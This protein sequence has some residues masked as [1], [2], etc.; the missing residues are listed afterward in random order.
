MAVSRFKRIQAKTV[1]GE[2]SQPGHEILSGNKVTGW[3]VNFPIG[4]TCKPSKLCAETC[5]GLKGPITWRAALSKQAR[6]LAYCKTDPVGFADALAT[7]CEKRLERDPGFFLRWNGVGDLFPEAVTAIRALSH[8]LPRLPIWCVTRIPN[9]ARQLYGI[10]NLW[11]HFSLD[12]SSMDRY[13]AMREDLGLT[14]NLFFSY[15]SEPG[16]QLTSLPEGVKVLFFHGYEITGANSN[17]RDEPV[18]CPLN[19]RTELSGTCN[20]CRRCFGGQDKK[21]GQGGAKA[22]PPR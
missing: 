8:R 14:E 5:Y 6:N 18:V 10:E 2:P 15:Q 4:R 20:Q 11:I 21:E 16:E 3:S 9:F 12:R 22:V 1:E 17:W 7:E 19:T 13:E